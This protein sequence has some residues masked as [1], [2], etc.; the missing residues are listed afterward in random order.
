GERII[1]LLPWIGQADTGSTAYR[2]E[3]LD[4]ILPL[5]IANPIMGVPDYDS[6]PELQFLRQGEGLIDLVNS[7]IGVAVGSGLIGLAL[8][9]TVHGVALFG[10]W[11]LLRRLDGDARELVRVLFGVYA[12]VL[13][14]IATTSS[15]SIIPPLTWAFAGASSALIAYHAPQ[16]RRPEPRKNG[17]RRS[18]NAERYLST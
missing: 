2:K 17:R 1:D 13:A 8:F 18:L 16:R 7:Y 9:V 11:R 4:A 3:L 10:L 6:R 15:I 12:T 14:A 5:L